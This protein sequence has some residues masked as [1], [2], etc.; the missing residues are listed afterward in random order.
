MI[1]PAGLMRN[2]RG[3]REA[4]A[5]AST[6]GPTNLSHRAPASRT[7]TLLPRLTGRRSPSSTDPSRYGFLSENAHFAKSRSCGV[8]SSGRPRPYP[9]YGRQGRSAPPMRAAGLPVLPAR[10]HSHHADD[11]RASPGHRLSGHHQGFRGGGGRGMRVSLDEALRAASVSPS[12]A[13]A[14]SKTM[15]FTSRITW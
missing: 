6:C 14:R 15:P 1:S 2:G 7:P 10:S 11:A 13:G 9:P 3:V 8:T 4:I 5:T 12:E